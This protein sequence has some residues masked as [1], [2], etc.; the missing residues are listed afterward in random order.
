MKNGQETGEH[1]GGTV[2][3]SDVAV[4]LHFLKIIRAGM[5]TDVKY[6]HVGNENANVKNHLPIILKYLKGLKSEYLR[7]CFLV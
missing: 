7:V 5:Q 1:S 6:F 2:L 3:T 4:D